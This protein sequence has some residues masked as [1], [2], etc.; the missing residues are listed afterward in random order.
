MCLRYGKQW[1]T[2]VTIK[3]Y[4]AIVRPLIDVLE[5][6]KTMVDHGYHKTVS[7]WKDMLETRKPLDD[8]GYHKTKYSDTWT[9]DTYAW[10][11]ENNPWPWL[12]INN[13]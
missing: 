6:R 3:Q 5:T 1:L 7:S 2:M 11:K 10:D 4:I 13:I 12:P 8:N 9:M